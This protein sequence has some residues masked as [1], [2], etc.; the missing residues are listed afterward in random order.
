VSE[1]TLQEKLSRLAALSGRKLT[2]LPPAQ[3]RIAALQVQLTATARQDGA[4]WALVAAALGHGDA[5]R[6]KRDARRLETGVRR[7]L[8]LQVN[9][10]ELAAAAKADAELLP[11]E[12]HDGCYWPLEDP[13]ER[14]GYDSRVPA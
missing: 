14:K 9:A 11:D 6:A 12:T 13:P 1:L 7:Y 4:T 5:V 3:A 2:R 10:A 8:R